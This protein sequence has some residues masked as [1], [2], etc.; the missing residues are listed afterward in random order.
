MR[1]RGAGGGGTVRRG[2]NVPNSL[3]AGRGGLIIL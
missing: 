1:V 3:S 2:H